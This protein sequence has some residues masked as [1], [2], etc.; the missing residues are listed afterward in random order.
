MTGQ[1]AYLPSHVVDLARD[2]LRNSAGDHIYLRPRSFAVL[3]TLAERAGTLVTKDEIFE[4][5]WDDATVTE[6]SLTQCIAEIRRAIGDQERRILRTVPRR[7]YVLTSSER[8]DGDK[9]R[10]LPKHRDTLFQL[11]L[12]NIRALYSFPS[13]GQYRLLRTIP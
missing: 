8:R 12:Q 7:G 2:E 1:K 3:R 5:V 4:N 6:D 13:S 9:L 10:P 11:T